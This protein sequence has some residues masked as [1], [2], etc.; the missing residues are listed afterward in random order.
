L[1]SNEDYEFNTRIRRSGRRIWLDPEIVSV[2][3]SRSTFQ[4]LARQYW[5]YG[6]WKFRMLT[7]YPET[8]RWRQALPPLLV[9]SLI[10]LL[11]LV[12]WSVARW[13][14]VLEVSLYIC[15]L[16]LTGLQ[17]ALRHRYAAF[18][19]G[20]PMAIATMHL[21]WGTGFLGSLIATGLEKQANG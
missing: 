4:E 18:I 8:L 9:L 5:R 6:Y 19:V 1:L 15:V 17:E 10:G 16:L 12:W 2:Y 13:G 3:Y 21:A 14:L 7:R 11:L 20:V